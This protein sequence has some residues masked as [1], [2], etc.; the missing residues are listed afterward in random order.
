MSKSVLVVGGAS[1][2]T[3]IHLDNFPQ[4][5]PQTLLA[6]GSYQ[7]V[8]GTGA[9]KAFNLKQL[10]MDVRLHMILGKDEAGHAILRECRRRD[11]P[12]IVELIDQ[13]TEQHTNLMAADGG[14]IS[15]FTHPSAD[16]APLHWSDLDPALKQC[17]IAAVSILNYTRPVLARARELG[18]PLWIDLHD[19]DGVNP[20]HDEFIQAADALF[21]SSDNFPDYRVFMAQ[22]VADGKDFVVCTHGARGSTALDAE[23]NWYEQDIAEGFELVDSNG[24]G[25]AF[26]SGFLYGYCQGWDMRRRLRAGTLAAAFCITSTQLASD[27]LSAAALEQDHLSAQDQN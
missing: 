5:Q 26:F 8:G 22:Q 15:I 14:R 19:Y 25:D 9:G 17:D 2:N 24:A 3:L 23:G 1:F 12:C 6:K 13:P 4:P 21:L 27:L 20:Y 18:K 16:E 7:A 11:L 10:G